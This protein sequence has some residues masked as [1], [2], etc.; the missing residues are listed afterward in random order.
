VALVQTEHG[1]SERMSC[2]LMGVE[3]SNYQYE[4]KPDRNA[5][6]RLVLVKLAWQK[7]RYY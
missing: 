1:L 7:P 5:E 6:L 4:P 2:K 3:G